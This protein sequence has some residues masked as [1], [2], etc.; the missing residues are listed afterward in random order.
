[1]GSRFGPGNAA[2]AIATLCGLYRWTSWPLAIFY[3]Q[4]LL[5]NFNYLAQLTASSASQAHAVRLW[6]LFLIGRV[7][8]LTFCWLRACLK[9]LASATDVVIQNNFW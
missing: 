6:W 1:M 2:Y 3:R 7:W 9:L 4:L 5:S 8:S